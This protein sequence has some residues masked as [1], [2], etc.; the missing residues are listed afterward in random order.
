M[1]HNQALNAKGAQLIWSSAPTIR[2]SSTTISPGAIRSGLL[3]KA[4]IKH[5]RF[6][7]YQ[8]S[9]HGKTKPSDADTWSGV[10]V[11]CPS[12]PIGARLRMARDNSPKNGR[13]ERVRLSARKARLDEASTHPKIV[14][15]NLFDLPGITDLEGRWGCQQSLTLPARDGDSE[16]FSCPTR[17]ADS[18]PRWYSPQKRYQIP[19]VDGQSDRGGRRWRMHFLTSP[20]LSPPNRTAPG[21]IVLKLARLHRCSDGLQ[22]VG[23]MLEHRSFGYT[24]DVHN[25]RFIKLLKS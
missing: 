22:S 6:I 20:R 16:I 5:R 8:I 24:L 1:F 15:L 9:V 14:Q 19:W 13:G 2:R 4:P 3:R 17:K 10:M 11:R 25:L 23:R 7:L 12:L 18:D 21:W